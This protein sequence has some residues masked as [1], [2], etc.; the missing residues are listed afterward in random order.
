MN[1]NDRYV[2]HTL[3]DCLRRMS[4]MNPYNPADINL[5]TKNFN[6]IEDAIPL[7]MQGIVNLQ[8]RDYVEA[9]ENMKEALEILR[10]EKKEDS[11]L[12]KTIEEGQ[13][14]DSN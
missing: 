12:A 14:P 5:K 1:S 4:L 9:D 13:A 10:D 11:N 6:L 8:Y 2:I 7:M 3:Y